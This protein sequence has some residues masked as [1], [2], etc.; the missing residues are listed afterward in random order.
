[1]PQRA[2]KSVGP[3]APRSLSLRPL[4][5]LLAPP[6][7]GGLRLLTPQVILAC[8]EPQGQGK[9]VTSPNLT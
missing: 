1:M 5:H 6:S 2:G 7:A 4:G 3:R 8:Y 9:P